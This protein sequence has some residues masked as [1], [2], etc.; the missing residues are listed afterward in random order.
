MSFIQNS[1]L[2]MF[3]RKR[4]ARISSGAVS[5]LLII[6][7]LH[8]SSSPFV[9]LLEG[10]I[11]AFVVVA[12]VSK[13]R[14]RAA[15]MPILEFGVPSPPVP[16]VTDWKTTKETVGHNPET[17]GPVFPVVLLGQWICSFCFP[18]LDRAAGGRRHGITHGIEFDIWEDCRVGPS[19]AAPGTR[20]GQKMGRKSN[21]IM[22]P[23]TSE[24]GNRRA[25][26]ERSYGQW[27][28]LLAIAPAKFPHKAAFA[29]LSAAFPNHSE[30][31][32]KHCDTLIRRHSEGK[33]NPRRYSHD[34]TGHSR[35]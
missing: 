13:H 9:F 27:E 7:P 6:P 18:Q 4:A 8:G 15:V 14:R 31:Y 19:E 3:Y 28:S 20:Q 30:A 32:S 1:P 34:A 12:A 24:D 2:E 21:R 11:H 26:R 16:G 23:E 17:P 22:R 33:I 35:T 10:L 25:R 5:R 29:G